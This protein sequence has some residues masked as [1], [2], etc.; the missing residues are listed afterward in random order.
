[1]TWGATQRRPA[2]GCK[3]ADRHNRNIAYRCKVH[4]LSCE[5]ANPCIIKGSTNLDQAIFL[6]VYAD[7]LFPLLT[8]C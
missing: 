3:T 1:M 4:P 5:A 6:F 7:R 8:I 2:P